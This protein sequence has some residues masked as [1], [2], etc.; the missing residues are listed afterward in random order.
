VRR[1]ADDARAAAEKLKQALKKNAEKG[2]H[3]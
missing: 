3:D 1:A 2:H